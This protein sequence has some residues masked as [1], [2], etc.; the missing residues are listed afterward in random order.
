MI[1]DILCKINN[2]EIDEEKACEIF[3]DIVEKFHEGVLNDEP[4]E[5]LKLDIFEYTAVSYGVDFTI[6]AQWRY[7]GWPNSCSRCNK[8]IDYKKGGWIVVDNHLTGINCCK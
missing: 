8:E 6:L 1:I 5:I 2:Q 3:D 7:K 4:K